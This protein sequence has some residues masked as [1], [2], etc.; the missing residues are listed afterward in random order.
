MQLVGAP[1]RVGDAQQLTIGQAA[2]GVQVF[3]S[4]AVEALGAPQRAGYRHA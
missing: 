1:Q 4:V 3:A 2:A